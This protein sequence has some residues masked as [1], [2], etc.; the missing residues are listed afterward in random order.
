MAKRAP[1]KDDH[2][3]ASSP[4]ALLEELVKFLARRAAERDDE[5]PRSKP[6]RPVCRN[7]GKRD[8]R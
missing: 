2:D 1:R 4:G 6:E 3:S 7:G 8:S 5:K